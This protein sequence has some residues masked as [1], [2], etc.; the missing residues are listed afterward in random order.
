MKALYEL[1]IA[2]FALAG[3]GLAAVPAG[4]DQA[5]D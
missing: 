1:M 5:I 4:A 3:A 2:T